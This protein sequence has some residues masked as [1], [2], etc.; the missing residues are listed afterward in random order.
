[1]DK[2]QAAVIQA[3]MLR[4]LRTE[5][6]EMAIDFKRGTICAG[7]VD[8]TFTVVP[9]GDAGKQAKAKEGWDMLCSMFGLK[10]EH[11]GRKIVSAKKGVTYTLSGINPGAAKFP[12]T[13]NGSDGK[14][15]KLA[16]V[17]VKAQLNA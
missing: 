5:F 9:G 17:F 16:P 15:Y 8:M 14:E 13:A 7:A 12:I 6:P 10:P 4:A 11:F 2:K 1:M 3:R